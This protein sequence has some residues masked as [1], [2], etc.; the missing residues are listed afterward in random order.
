M[1]SNMKVLCGAG[2]LL[3]MV[4]VNPSRALAANAYP[5]FTD[6]NTDGLLFGVTD[7]F[8]YGGNYFA[9]DLAQLEG[10]DVLMVGQ[11]GVSSGNTGA[12]FSVPI[13]NGENGIDQTFDG[14]SNEDL[15]VDAPNM[16]AANPVFSAIGNPSGRLENGNVVRFSAWYRS[17]PANPIVV[18][19]Q[20][21]PVLKI[22]LW[23]EALS[24]DMPEESD[25]GPGQLFPFYGDKV[26][27][28]DQHGGPV[29]IPVEDRAQWIDFNGDGMVIDGGAASE[30]RVSQ[31]STE[32]WTLVETMF[33]I[34]DTAE[35]FGWF[36]GDDP[37]T[38]ADIEEVRG[39]MFVGD[40]TNANLGG[41]S[42][43]GHLLVDN[44]LME[45]FRDAASVTPNTNPEPVPSVGLDGDFNGDGSVDAADYVVWRKNALS[46]DDYEDWV[47]NFGATSP[48]G[49]ASGLSTG[50]VPEPSTFVLAGLI[51]SLV[52]AYRGRRS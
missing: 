51:L 47:A 3:L 1:Q 23:K 33:T 24:G 28:Q 9:E 14:G 41:D 48:G 46:Q 38:V 25:T 50:A 39:V 49:G 45:I 13:S 7:V 17:D 42:D 37:Y 6:I 40:F 43:G 44:A 19:P 29:Q 36:I 35:G 52:V 11:F 22:E 34:D 26:F 18:D 8:A 15:N 2:L 30:G 12:G 20:I 5:V 21:Q 32:S 16:T 10:N 27:D 4:A 31:I